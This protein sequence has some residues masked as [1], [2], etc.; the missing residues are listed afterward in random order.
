MGQ[1]KGAMVYQD[2]SL[3]E[4]TVA[5]LESLNLETLATSG[6]KSIAGMAH[7][8]DLAGGSGP[9]GAIDS[10]LQSYLKRGFCEEGNDLLLV[11]V[12][13][14]RLNVELLSGLIDSHH[15]LKESGAVTYY[16]NEPLPVMLSLSRHLPETIRSILEAEHERRGYSLRALY[17]K[18]YVNELVISQDSKAG[19]LNCN[20]PED[21]L[22]L[23]A[24]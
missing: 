18:L 5:L 3:L 22:K 20:S 24:K 14:P 4:R 7:I 21:W 15:A 8:S 16:M 23:N 2:K 12:D 19:L 1:D 6:G 11:P 17:N 10:I 9:L 13:M